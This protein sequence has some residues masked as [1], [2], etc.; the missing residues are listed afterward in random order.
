PSH[1]S[2]A[3]HLSCS[4]VPLRCYLHRLSRAPGVKRRRLRTSANNRGYCGRRLPWKKVRASPAPPAVPRGQTWNQ[5]VEPLYISLPRCRG[6][7]WSSRAR[8]GSWSSRSPVSSTP[9]R[10]TTA[11]LP[12][13]LSPSPRSRARPLRWPALLTARWNRSRKCRRTWTRSSAARASRAPSRSTRSTPRAARTPGASTR[14]SPPAPRREARKSQPALT[15]TQ[16]TR[17]AFGRS[18]RI[19]GWTP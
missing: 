6:A 7:T 4:R 1:V 12:P 16:S 14:A 5:L 15:R 13:S 9:P 2:H 8:A 3:H 17:V 11:L 19:W 10:R 18:C